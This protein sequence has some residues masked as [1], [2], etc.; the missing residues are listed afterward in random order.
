MVTFTFF[1]LPRGSFRWPC[2][3]YNIIIETLLHIPAFVLSGDS[4]CNATCTVRSNAPPVTV[5]WTSITQASA[6]INAVSPSDERDEHIKSH[7]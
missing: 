2:Q 6:V 5:P 1:A 7:L 3:L 4:R